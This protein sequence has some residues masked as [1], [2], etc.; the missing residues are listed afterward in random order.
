MRLTLCAQP[1]RLTDGLSPAACIDAGRL[2]D[3]AGCDIA[4]RVKGNRPG[5]LCAESRDI[6]A[7]D[8]CPHGCA[9]CYAVADPDKA[10]ATH[11]AHDPDA[12]SL[13]PAVIS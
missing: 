10:R 11:R 2:S 1:D 9:Y 7:D 12:E 5:C 4:A 13:S 8:T 6:A 3:V